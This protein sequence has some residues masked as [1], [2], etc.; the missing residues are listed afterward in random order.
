MPKQVATT[1][2]A[3][4]VADASYEA[5]CG[6]DATRAAASRLDS[7]YNNGQGG[8]MFAGV[9]GTPRHSNAAGTST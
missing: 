3:K 2:D 8:S 4:P 5:A 6:G 9:N 7:D 1:S